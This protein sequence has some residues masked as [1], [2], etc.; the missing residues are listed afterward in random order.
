MKT[1]TIEIDGKTYFVRV[2]YENRPQARASIGR[3]TVNIRLPISIGR[4]EQFRQLL[5]MKKWVIDRL[6]ESPEKFKPKEQKQYDDGEKL[7]IGEEEFTLKIDFK[8]KNSSSAR[9]IKD[10]IL[11][12]I[13]GNLSKD[14]QNKHV[15]T[16]LS[17]CIASKRLPVLQ[18]KIFE[19]NEK[20]FNQKVNKIFFK[21]LKS[22]WGSCS[23]NSNINISTRLLFAPDDVLEYV[24]IHELAH[25]LEHN[26]SENFWALVEKALPDYKQKS[27][28]LKQNGHACEF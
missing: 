17:R 23:K 3:N 6:K 2:H 26:H 21:N 27:D 14:R 12:S 8:D 11:L 22:K 5:E 13:S 7:K 25:L 19:L 9:I 28:W 1:E 10:T 24:C 4:G 20:H 15:S 16:L 18:Q